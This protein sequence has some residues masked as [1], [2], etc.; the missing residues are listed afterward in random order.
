M[1]FK[2]TGQG[3]YRGLHEGLLRD[4]SAEP[5]GELVE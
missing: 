4:N 1:N 2:L 3:V 5:P